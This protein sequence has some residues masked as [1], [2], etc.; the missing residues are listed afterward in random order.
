MIEDFDPRS[1][2][3]EVLDAAEWG[4]RDP[5][6]IKMCPKCRGLAP[7]NPMARGHEPACTWAAIIAGLRE[8]FVNMPKP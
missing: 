6:G 5:S 8:Q 3:A 2:M 7:P 1:F 4:D